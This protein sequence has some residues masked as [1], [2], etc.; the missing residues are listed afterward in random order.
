[1]DVLES[2]KTK[3]DYTELLKRFYTLYEPLEAQLEGA[4]DWPAVGWDFE[5]RR[6]TPWLEADLQALG[7]SADELAHWQRAQPAGPVTDLGTAVGTLYVIEGSTLGGQMIAKQLLEPMGI[8]RENGGK[9]FR[10]YGAE[11]GQRWREFGQWA[12]AQAARAPLSDA[13]LRGARAT[14]EEFAR[15][16]KS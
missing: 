9:F 13:A 12:E 7:V 15:W 6:K 2:V 10:A 4:V 3:A 16:M 8:T 1:M 5:G 14:F 11:T